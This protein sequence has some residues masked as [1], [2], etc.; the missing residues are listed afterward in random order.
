MFVLLNLLCSAS[1]VS[2][3]SV[4]LYAVLSSVQCS[5]VHYSAV[6]VVSDDG[7]GNGFDVVKCIEKPKKILNR[8]NLDRPSVKWMLLPIATCIYL[9]ILYDEASYSTVLYGMVV[10]G[11]EWKRIEEWAVAM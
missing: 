3:Y 1:E 5:T 4:V 6:I 9:M 11:M 7:N 8:Q 2:M 10:Y